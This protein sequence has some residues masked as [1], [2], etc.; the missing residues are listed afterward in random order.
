MTE[1]PKRR[2]WRKLGVFGIALFFA[3][4]TLLLLPTI[5]VNL[6]TRSMRYELSHT[7]IT[8]I[9]S[10][11]VAIVFG[12][13]L[14]KRGTE[15]SNFLLW[16]VETAAK[17]YHAGKVQAILMSGD[18]SYYDHDEPYIMKREAISLGV[19]AEA[20]MMDKFGFDTYD[21]CSRAVKY[22]DISSAIVV[23]QGYHVPRAIFTCTNVGIDTVGVNAQSEPGKGFTPYGIVRE[24]LSTDKLFVQLFVRRFE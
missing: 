12:A 11:D 4:A 21:S 17:L 14:R 23:S 3:L 10:R 6:T 15:P 20:I 24:W 1:R 18:G 22:R 5:Y 2:R 8:D 13:A 16:R 7:D 9:P 19:P